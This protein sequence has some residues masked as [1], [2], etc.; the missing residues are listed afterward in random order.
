MKHFLVVLIACLVPS[1]VLQAKSP[2]P[3]SWESEIRAF[4]TA[5]RTANPAMGGVLFVGSSSIRLWPDLAG[6]FPGVSTINRGFGGSEIADATHFVDRIIVP[7]APRQVVL[8]AGD[9]D[10]MNGRTPEAVA[11]AFMAFVDAI[12]IR[13]PTVR[14]S[15]IAIK[16]SPA[17]AQLLSRASTANALIR[18]FA[19]GAVDVDFIDIHTPMLDAHGA[20]R[21][22]LFVDDGLH[23]NAHGYR[24]WR[25]AVAPY[26]R[27]P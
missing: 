17:R 16:P 4:E 26:L 8:Y 10:L 18:R 22:E 2:P 14:I 23:L 27:A 25:I 3:S 7:Y 15:F 11:S 21:P 1:L 13:L 20:P 12:R 19:A 9:N 6:D 24:L 5:D